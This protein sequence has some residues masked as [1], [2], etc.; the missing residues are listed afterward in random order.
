M[1]TTLWILIL[2]PLLSSDTQYGV[3]TFQS[4]GDFY[5]AIN[6]ELD[7]EAANCTNSIPD[8]RRLLMNV[9]EPPNDQTGGKMLT[10]YLLACL[11]QKI[12]NINEASPFSLSAQ[13]RI[14]YDIV[15]NQ[16]VSLSFEGTFETKARM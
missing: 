2:W 10:E 16:V 11:H 5:T 12:L 7:E 6:K 9:H 15:L 1:R 4:T 13:P 3:A 14:L 8:K